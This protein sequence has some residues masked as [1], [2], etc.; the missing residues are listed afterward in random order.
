MIACVSPAESNCAETLSTL[1]YSNRARNIRNRLSI[2]QENDGNQTFE[3]IQL[4]KQIS[5]LKQEILMMRGL[6][7]AIKGS[8]IANEKEFKGLLDEKTKLE[9]EN[10]AIKAVLK[11]NNLIKDSD[12]NPFEKSSRMIVNEKDFMKMQELYPVLK[13]L[14]G[15]VNRLKL[16]ASSIKSNT[17][18]DLLNRAKN[19]ICQNLESL[20]S[21]RAN[22]NEEFEEEIGK[23]LELKQELV[24]TIERM[25]R[26]YSIMQEKYENQLR[27]LQ[28][29]LS[30]AQKERESALKN[31]PLKDDL[32]KVSSF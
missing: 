19:E 28:S 29:S 22:D 14:L 23:D 24:S 5:S 17:G 32:S 4:K 13:D 18:N 25:Q 1:R 26:E 3:I 20:Q 7:P 12:R 21:R 6:A 27:L 30:V 15:Q 8:E 9:A 10:E 31:V 16:Q 2:N 11:S